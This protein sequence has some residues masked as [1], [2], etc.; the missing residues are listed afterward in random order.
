M[1]TDP[2]HL[3]VEDP[4]ST[5][6]NAV[7]EHLFAFAPGAATEELAASYQR[8][9]LGD[10]KI[11]AQLLGRLEEML[12]PIRERRAAFKDQPELVAEILQRG[13]CRGCEEAAVTLER[14]KQ[15]MGLR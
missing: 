5:Q 2:G 6:G 10:T 7:F 15:V 14:M 1:Y 3:R 13:V 4:G 12:T 11:K 9:G 8:G